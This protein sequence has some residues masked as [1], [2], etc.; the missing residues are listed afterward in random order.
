M[1]SARTA[2][3]TLLDTARRRCGLGQAGAGPSA[4][5]VYRAGPTDMIA[6]PW[7]RRIAE[8]GDGRP[9]G[10]IVEAIW[11]EEIEAG[12][13]VVDIGLWK[14]LFNQKVVQA[15]DELAQRGVIH[16][17]P[18]LARREDSYA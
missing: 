17:V 12:A 6:D 13:W 10:E 18:A 7:E 1:I 4:W 2:F 3:H 16:I 11:R 9:T 8:M 5:L 15:I 14:G